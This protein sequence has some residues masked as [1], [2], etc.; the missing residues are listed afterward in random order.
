MNKEEYFDRDYDF[1]EINIDSRFRIAFKEMLIS[2]I[3]WILFGVCCLSTTY[4]FSR[5]PV[6]DYSYTLGIPTWMFCCL[7]SMLV[8][9]VIIT[10]VVKKV[11]KNIDLTDVKT[12]EAKKT[13]S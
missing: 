10:I 1:K 9:Y 11:F 3:I 8:F 6:E 5:G 4:Y 7:L 13:V 2:M 12:D